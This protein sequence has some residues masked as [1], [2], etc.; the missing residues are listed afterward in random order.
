MSSIFEL[1][2]QKKDYVNFIE[3]IRV[4][5]FFSMEHRSDV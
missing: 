5:S 1:A 4:T 2:S 3:I